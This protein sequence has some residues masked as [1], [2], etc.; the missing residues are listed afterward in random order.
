MRSPGPRWRSWVDILVNNAGAAR[1]YEES[2]SIPENEWQDALDINY[3]ASVRLTT[4][5]LPH[6]RE[7]G[8]GVSVNFSSAVVFAPLGQ[9]LHY[10]A[11]KSALETYSRGL[12]IE[13]APYGI[14]VNTVTPAAVTTSGGDLIREQ[15]A[16]AGAA[17]PNEMVTAVPLGCRGKPDDIANVVT[18]LASDRASW[19]TGREFVVDG[20]EFP[21]G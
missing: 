1:P 10:A 17:Q 19:I 15:I 20:G 4:A 21:R 13:V 18:F 3:L 2:S 9:A 6:M 7:R 16:A 14:R 11:A 8:S 12:A 5:L